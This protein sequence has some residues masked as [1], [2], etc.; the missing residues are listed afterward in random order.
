MNEKRTTPS[1]GRR[2]KRAAPTI[3]L[4][5]TEVQPAA[6]EPVQASSEPPQAEPVVETPAH[7]E[8]QTP[9]PEPPPVD[10]PRAD[11][12]DGANGHWSS[13]Q[14]HVTLPVLAA[15]FAGALAMS[16]VLFVLWLT[17]VV[18]IRYAGS[19]ATR[20]RVAALEMEMQA[21]QNRP[22][23]V[24]SKAIDALT[25]RVNTMQETIAKLPAGNAATDPALTERIAAADNAVKSLAAAVAALNKRNDDIAGAATQ[26]R[27]RADAAEKAVTELR[28]SVQIATT[29]TAGLSSADL[30]ALQKRIAV[31]EQSTQAARDDIAKTGASD[32][33][34]RLALSA[35]ALRDAV[36]SG[37]PYAAALSQVK[38]LGADEKMLAPLTQFAAT[39]VPSSQALAQELRALL[40]A[41]S[42]NA[43]P[44]TASE[45][46]FIERLQANAGKL[47][48]VRP[49]DAPAGEDAASILARAEIAAGKADIPAAL[50]EV[51]KLAEPVRAPAQ[52]WIA[53]VQARQAA[54]NAVRSLVAS[55]SSTL[56]SK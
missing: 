1:G 18:P 6:S 35:A 34:A 2:P 37:A 51:A 46:G 17:G 47:V 44:Q 26:A 42:K 31:L 48:K 12:S 29:A 3:D 7:S 49:V 40:P 13:I 33:A 32:A 11:A 50:A 41:M 24:D 9:P 52:A 23:A 53:K 16:V 4:A 8:N 5:A 22:A 20:A 25:A 45:G 28:S 10:P 36:F 15:G 39:G 21:L 27:D 30:D 19:T 14:K 43:A 38:T 55:T 56:G 54:A